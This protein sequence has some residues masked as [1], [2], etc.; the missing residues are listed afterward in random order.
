MRA[1]SNVGLPSELLGSHAR[2][3]KDVVPG[4]NKGRVGRSTVVVA[5]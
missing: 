1:R 3:G 5:A 4:K 2:R